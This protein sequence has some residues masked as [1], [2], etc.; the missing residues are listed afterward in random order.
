[1][2]RCRKMT[3]AKKWKKMAE[4]GETTQEDGA[5]GKVVKVLIVE[6]N[7]FN[8]LP[9]QATLNRHH[10]GYD[11]AKNGLMAVDRYNQ[12]MMQGY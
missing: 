8:V 10:I 3:V 1:M 11:L 2:L 9:I 6:D 12:S 4:Q 7:G 5:S